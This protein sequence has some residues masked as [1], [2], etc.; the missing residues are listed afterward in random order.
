MLKI[1]WQRILNNFMA[2]YA[3]LEKAD[4]VENIEVEVLL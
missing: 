4:Y 3:T 1:V 2:Y